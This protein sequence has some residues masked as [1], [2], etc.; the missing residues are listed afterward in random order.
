MVCEKSIHALL[1]EECIE[2]RPNNRIKPRAIVFKAND[3]DFNEIMRL[4][5]TNFSNV[6]IVYI[7][8]GSTTSILHVTKS[9]PS[10]TE[11]LSDVFYSNE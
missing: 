2:C 11:T 1:S 3:N 9:T 7:T 8:T 10:E 4:V 6:K 5:E